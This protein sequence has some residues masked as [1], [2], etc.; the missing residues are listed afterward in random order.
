MT[1]DQNVTLPFQLHYHRFQPC[2]EILV[3]LPPWIAIREFVLVSRGEV[4]GILL[5]DLLVCHLLAN[6]L[7]RNTER[8]AIRN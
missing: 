1:N 4:R 6:T 2:N 7:R 8:S 3:A 5:S